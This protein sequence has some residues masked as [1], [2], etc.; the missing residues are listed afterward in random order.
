M[1]TRDA[2]D[3]SPSVCPV[4]SPS[5]EVLRV[6]QGGRGVGGRGLGRRGSDGAGRGP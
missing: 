4:V 1:A 5:G 6:D 3:G 2:L